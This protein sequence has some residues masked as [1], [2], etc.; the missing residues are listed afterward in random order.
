M[1]SPAARQ[2]PEPQSAAVA[3]L[4]E[5]AARLGGEVVFEPGGHGCLRVLPDQDAVLPAP[6]DGTQLVLGPHV[7]HDPHRLTLDGYV[8]RIRCDT[9]AAGRR[10]MIG[11]QLHGRTQWFGRAECR[12]RP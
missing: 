1:I 8:L 11:S 7:A 2:T 10:A 3:R 4:P 12:P 9:D 6:A 5:D